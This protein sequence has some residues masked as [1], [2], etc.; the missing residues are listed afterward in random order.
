MNL[1]HEANQIHI[2]TKN[3]DV[4][5]TPPILS[6]LLNKLSRF[7]LIPTFGNEINAVTGESNH[8]VIM[9]NTQQS[10]RLEF[11]SHAIVINGAYTS[12]NDFITFS[13]E[14]LSELRS[15]FPDKKMN[16]V[17]LINT[18][19]FRDDVQKYKQLYDCLFTYHDVN[20]FEWDNRVAL[21]KNINYGN[22]IINSINTIRR[23][24]VGF[25]IGAQPVDSIMVEVD[26]NTTHEKT[27]MRLS[28]DDCLPILEELYIN[29]IESVHALNRYT[30]I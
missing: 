9:T 5:T 1:V 11:P 25:P 4:T 15:V 13:K 27:D 28:W 16:R 3:T 23:C 24:E 7:N 30:N 12:H 20:P 6:M 17:A 18:R 8:I 26:S 2:Y 22:E 29:N 10:Y 14:V 21:R 19:I